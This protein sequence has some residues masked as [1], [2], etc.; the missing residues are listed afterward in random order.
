VLCYNIAMIHDGNDDKTLKV[1]K[2]DD[3]I[4]ADSEISLQY[5]VA[6][7]TEHDDLTREP[8]HKHEFV[9]MV[10]TI[11]GHGAHTVDGKNYD[12]SPG[13]LLFINCGREHSFRMDADN[14]YINILLKPE[15]FQPQAE[16]RDLTDIFSLY[17][18]QEAD[19]GYGSAAGGVNRI[20]CAAFTGGEFVEIN[21]IIRYM[22][23][24]FC[25]K[26]PRYLDILRNYLDII[27]VKAIRNVES[28]GKNKFVRQVKKELHEAVLFINDNFQ[29]GITMHDVAAKFFYNPSYFARIFKE[30]LGKSFVRY[31]QE[32]RMETA[33]RML[34]E[35]D[36]SI[37]AVQFSV[38]YENKAQF[39]DIFKRY[40][41]MTPNRY[42]QA[43][44]AS[45][46]GGEKHK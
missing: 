42:R 26:A 17:F 7:D 8:P 41:N 16:T 33:M 27:I 37:E 36:Q 14:E 25:A 32:R 28:T 18:Q 22:W 46:N 12:V 24:E 34:L 29:T 11:N 6:R 31:V 21:G 10:F 43:G 39:Y 30:Y 45:G 15:F 4:G 40:T 9:E 23:A 3:E 44:R 19:E 1:F 35:T 38:G 13:S 2:A 20:T 5:I